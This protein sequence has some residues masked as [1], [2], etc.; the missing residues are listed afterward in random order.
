MSKEFLIILII[1]VAL[2]LLTYPFLGAMIKDKRELAEKTLE[3]LF[4]FFF[5][6]ISNGLFDGKGEITPLPDDPRCVNMMSTD[7][8]CQNMIVHFMYSTGKMTMEVGFKYFQEELRFQQNS[9]KMRNASAFVQKDIANAFV[10]TARKKI[11]EHKINVLRLLHPNEVIDHIKVEHPFDIDDPID[12]IEDSYDGFTKEQKEAIIAIGYLIATA[13]GSPESIFTSNPAVLQQI[14][15]FNVSW[16]NCKSKLQSSGEQHLINLLTG[17]NVDS[18]PVIEPF[19]SSVIINP[20]TGE[21]DPKKTQK[22]YDYLSAIGISK[23]EYDE[24]ALK[25]K[26]L[27]QMFCEK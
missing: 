19:F 25:N 11:Y 23:E 18:I 7:P 27:M 12:M 16:D 5:S 1:L 8:N 2:F 15:F 6:T 3:E 13:D 26:L 4:P 22:L 20:V 24:I 14:R 17:I 10:E 9:E 21:Q